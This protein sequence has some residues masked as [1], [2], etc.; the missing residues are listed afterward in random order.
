M[1]TTS[2]WERGSTKFSE[3]AYI[4]EKVMSR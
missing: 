1:C 4:R 2:S 3:K